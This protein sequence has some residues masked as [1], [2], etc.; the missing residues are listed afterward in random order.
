VWQPSNAQWWVLVAVALFVVAAWPSGEE[1][2]LAL[3]FVNWAVDPDDELPTLPAELDMAAG[4]D[5]DAVLA[6]DRQ[7]NAYFTLYDKGGWTR[8]R[9]LLK[10]A[11]EP[12]NPSTERQMLAGLGLVAALVVW[13]WS[14][15]TK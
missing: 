7:E 12:F 9:L 2:S 14:G 15:A 4:D 5:A 3:K 6:H 8:R 1:K 11:D 10:V 13:R